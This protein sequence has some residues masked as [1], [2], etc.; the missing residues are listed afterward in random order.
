MNYTEKNKLI[1]KLCGIGLM[2][3]FVEI[4]L[5]VVKDGFWSF[6]YISK[7]PTILNVA[8]GIFLAIGI[9][10]LIYAYRKGNGWRAI[11]G[12]EFVVLAFVSVLLPHTYIDFPAPWNMLNKIFPY[13]FLLYYVVKMI[14]VIIKAKKKR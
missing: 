11:Y 3:I 5:A 9:A 2:L 6:S 13:A 7:M 4:F 12:I 8:G 1:D 14:V 10:I